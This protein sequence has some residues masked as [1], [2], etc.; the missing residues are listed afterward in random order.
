[1]IQETIPAKRKAGRPRSDETRKAILSSA[2]QIVEEIGFGKLTIEGVAL[3]AKAGKATI[4]RWWPNKA[5]MVMEA[6]LDMMQAEVPFPDTGNVREDFRRQLQLSVQVLTSPKG[7]VMAMLIGCGQEDPELV[8]AFRTNFLRTRR[9]EATQVLLR[10]MRRGELR[11]D[12]YPDVALDVL[13]GALF[14]RLMVG[15]GPLTPDY[16]DAVCDAVMSGLASKP[17]AMA[18]NSQ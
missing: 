14:F 8:E 13:Y 15:H 18:A 12:V 3:R 17:G 10:G 1:M 9:A 7:K 5:A 2:M 11:S 4:Y 16:V 6:Y